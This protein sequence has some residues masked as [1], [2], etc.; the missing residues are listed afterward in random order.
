[1]K[2]HSDQP[3][4][5]RRYRRMIV[6][7][8]IVFI[9]LITRLF[10]LQIISH[11][12][13]TTLSR[14]NFL[15]V[16]AKAPERGLIYDRNGVLLAKNIPSYTLSLIPGKIKNMDATL[17]DLRATL[18]IDNLAIK[19]FK[20]RLNQYHP[21]DLAPLPTKLNEQQIDRFYVNAYRFPGVSITA[22]LQREYPLKSVGSS[23]VGYVG[24][25][26]D[27]D[28]NQL[29]KNNY[30]AST[31]IG[32]TGIE[33][34]LET[35]LHGS[36]GIQQVEINARGQIVHTLSQQPAHAGPTLHLTIDSRLQQFIIKTLGDLSAAVVAIDPS[37][38]DILAMV[39]TPT[40]DTN[41]F[42]QGMSTQEYHDLANN[43]H[44]P[45]YNKTIQG[46]YSPGS[47]IKPFYAVSALDNGVITPQTTINDPGWF[48]LPN[49]THKF[50]DWKPQ[51]HGKVNIKKAIMVSC[52]TYFYWLSTKMGI[53]LIDH[54]LKT[55]GF[56]ASTQIN[57]PSESNG[58]IPSP[59][60]KSSHQGS[61]WYAGDTVITGIGQGSLLVTPLQLASATAT[62][63]M[64]GKHYQPHL[65]HSVQTDPEH[66]TLIEPQLTSTITLNN[67]HNWDIVIDALQDVVRSPHGTAR[68]FGPHN[69]TV[70]AKTG[71]AQVYGHHRDEV[72]VQS[73]VPW[74]LRNN[75]LFIDFAPVEQPKIALALVIEH[76][77][78]ADRIAGL[79]TTYYLTHCLNNDKNSSTHS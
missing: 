30:L 31:Y 70:A 28:L 51:G 23:V 15:N 42:S 71:T 77:G 52:D 48:S 53:D 7:V 63:A 22:S 73:N 19:R 57:L 43:P 13:Y 34:G 59:E 4:F 20:H 65:V 44:H 21:Y 66:S 54:T 64:H 72:Y 33:K 46:L 75:H 18:D 36:T 79:I 49:S 12:Q 67:P 27:Q 26:N 45:L 8:C 32:K 3:D 6:G 9:I 40:Y 16:M 60:W 61:P 56:G 24:K 38:G 76:D 2:Q 41:L 55:F 74:K 17:E 35:T 78:G 69:Y 39:S 29:N 68:Y 25:I 37:N 62:L 14:H 11:T 1:M 50:R 10:Y 58:T 47:T 5:Q